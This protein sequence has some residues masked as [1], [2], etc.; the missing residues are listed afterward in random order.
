MQN[1]IAI[2][3]KNILFNKLNSLNLIALGIFFIYFFSIVLLPV[4]DSIINTRQN[5]LPVSQSKKNIFYSSVLKT[6]ANI[7]TEVT[8]ATY[9]NNRQTLARQINNNNLQ[10]YINDAKGSVL[11][12]NS[13]DSANIQSYNYDA[14][15][16]PI[17]L[18]KPEIQNSSPKPIHASNSLVVTIENPFQYTSERFDNNTNLQ[19]LSA[20]FYNP[21]IRRFVNQDT[22]SFLNKFEY[23]NSN[24][25]MYSD[26]TGHYSWNDF[27]DDASY[28]WSEF[29]SWINQNKGL[30]SG[31]V[32]GAA[33][34]YFVAR[35]TATM[36]KT[37]RTENRAFALT[38]KL[39]KST[40]L[41]LSDNELAYVVYDINRPGKYNIPRMLRLYL[42]PTRFAEWKNDFHNTYTLRIGTYITDIR[43]P[44]PFRALYGF[45]H[46]NDS[47]ENPTFFN[48]IKM[49][50]GKRYEP[51]P[52]SEE[53]RY[54][55]ESKPF[56]DTLYRPLIE[57]AI[58][59]VGLKQKKDGYNP[60]YHNCQDAITEVLCE[61]NKLCNTRL[62]EQN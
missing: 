15:G 42:S 16:N 14:Y 3:T 32:V 26:P 18:E 21:G 49:L 45:Y 34:S 8:V 52:Q 62:N 13:S 48:F 60:L 41:K 35:R 28:A 5:N 61:Y 12:L 59:N 58:Q 25:V 43:D 39:M 56:G 50:L 44:K 4:V 6:K 33:A 10:N 2:K 40:R 46:F 17:T 47:T 57:E 51:K 36:V 53:N 27:K 22:Y 29:S 1:Y 20:R 31:I 11:K 54:L 38:K 30:F 23:G 24:P 37:I 19:C 9:I 55:P 7:T